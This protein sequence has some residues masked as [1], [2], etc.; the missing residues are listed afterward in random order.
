MP[1]EP[2]G[3]DAASV[4]EAA[5][6][7]IKDAGFDESNWPQEPEA[8]EV[9]GQVDPGVQ[10]TLDKVRQA[11]GGD[12]EGDQEAQTPP[13]GDPAGQG[14]PEPPSEDD[15]PTE[16]FGLDLSGLPAPKRQEVI[17][18]F[19]A[20]DRYI[21]SLQKR[22]P[23]GQ[24]PQGTQ[25]QTP[26]EEPEPPKEVTDDDIM[27]F[28]G[29]SPD[30]PMYEVKKEIMVPIAKPLI[31]TAQTV[32][33]FQQQ[34]ELD[35]FIDHWETTLDRM[36]K[37]YGK[38]PI[39]REELAVIAEKEGIFEP[40]MA[41]ARVALEGRAKLDKLR[42]EALAELERQDKNTDGPKPP[43]TTRP[44]PTAPDDTKPTGEQK[45]LSPREAALAAAKATG[46]DWGDTLKALN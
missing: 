42:Q 31:E 29:V 46:L 38:L 32:Q 10:A 36:E 25:Q 30:D 3:F 34:Q 40:E 26:P 22:E 8:D 37:D 7:A 13:A 15:V 33:A 23:E 43:S 11:Q 27:K 24:E 1:D 6:Q 28:L 14:A 2:E 5:L 44:G 19:K 18:A 39:S 21:Q 12:G 17:E 41:Y 4:R 16:Y 9:G 20:Q 45:L 35:A